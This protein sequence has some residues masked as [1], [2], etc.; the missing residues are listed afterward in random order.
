MVILITGPSFTGKTLLAQRL[1]EK[2]KYPYLSTFFSFRLGVYSE[3]ILPLLTL[4]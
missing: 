1:L 4:R 3:T 2:N